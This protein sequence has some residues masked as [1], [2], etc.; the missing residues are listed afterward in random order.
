MQRDPESDDGLQ[1]FQEEFKLMD[2][3]S[4]DGTAAPFQASSVQVTARYTH[5][6][7]CNA[8]SQYLLGV[9]HS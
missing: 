7:Y 8:R 1:Q 4:T 2:V 3:T 5:S 6:P 9:S